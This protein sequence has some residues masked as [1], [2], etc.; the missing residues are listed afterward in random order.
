MDVSRHDLSALEADTGYS[1]ENRKWLER[2]LT[3]SSSRKDPGSSSPAAGDDNEHLEL[4]GDAVLGLVVTQALL[5]KFPSWSVGKLSQAR[6]QLVNSRSLHA[7]AARLELGRH[8]RLG[9]GEEKS[10]LREQRDVLA[11]AFEALIGAIFLDGGLGAAGAFVH[12]ALLQD[13]LE[14]PI[15]SLGTPDEKSALMG[16]FQARGKALPEY[17]VVEERGP[18][19]RKWFVV[20]VTAEGKALATGE[21][22]SK[23]SAELAAARRALVALSADSE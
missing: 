8:L 16:W 20:E 17:H 13:A 9:K 1:F 4:L 12:R 23:K 11:D 3:H 6:A 5:E 18:D 2:A 15:A 10:G 21:G 14:E 19:H 7:A 22:E